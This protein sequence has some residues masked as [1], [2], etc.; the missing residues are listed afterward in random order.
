MGR[1]TQA[2]QESLAQRNREKAEE[3][4]K[5]AA[6]ETPGGALGVPSAWREQGKVFDL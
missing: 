5:L 3:L 1:P 6:S 4:Q 2:R